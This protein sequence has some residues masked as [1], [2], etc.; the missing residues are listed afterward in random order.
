MQRAWL[1]GFL[2]VFCAACLALAAGCGESEEETLAKAAAAVAEAREAVKTA[3]EQVDS[4]QAAASAAD[5]ELATARDALRQAEDAL[6]TA[7]GRI[8][9]SATDAVVFRTLQ[10]RLLEADELEDLAVAAEVVKGV[11]TLRG[12]VPDEKTRE[13]ALEIARS[14]PG[15]LAVESRVDV[16]ADVAAD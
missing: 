7:E 3:R 5:Q 9:T 16:A 6:R 15:V 2:G 1:G 8:D 11:A 14:T 13:I 10:K 12:S 4:R